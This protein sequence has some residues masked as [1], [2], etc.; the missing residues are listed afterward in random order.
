MC[1]G[2]S[3]ERHWSFFRHLFARP[4]IG[5]CLVLGVYYGRDMAYMSAI[6]E[7]TGRR[8]EIVGVDKFD[9]TPGE[10]WPSEL[11]QSTW[12]E[13]GFGPPP[14]IESAREN[15][16]RLGFTSHIQ[17]HRGRA[18]DYLGAASRAFD[19]VYI[20]TSHD[21]ATTRRL[22]D[23]AVPRLKRGGLIGGDDFSDQGTWGVA[24]AVQESFSRFEV[25]SGWI[26]LAR[27][28]DYRPVSPA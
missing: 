19:F 14:D 25:F 20:D 13:A 8:A 18:E 24:S 22:I 2:Y 9:D 27:G 4:E 15:L 3:S 6:L 17:L 5:T 21:Y 11:H 1:R 16:S 23:L 12:R 26:W 7:L 28:D 10:D